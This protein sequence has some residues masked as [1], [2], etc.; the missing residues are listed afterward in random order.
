VNLQDKGKEAV[1]AGDD[2][3]DVI[4]GK[5]VHLNG[6]ATKSPIASSP[7]SRAEMPSP[8]GGAALPISFHPRG[9][10]VLVVGSNRLASS[11]AAAF[12]EA[13]GEVTIVSGSSLSATHGDIQERVRQSQIVYQQVSM[14]SLEEWAMY[15]SENDVALVCVT[16]T[17]IGSSQRS[18]ES[19]RIIS[20]ACSSLHI[21]VSVS[22]HPSLSTYTFPSVHRFAGIAGPSNLQIAVSTNGQ[23]CRLSSRIKREIISRLPHN[24]G[25][26]V[27]NVGRLREKA[28]SRAKHQSR[29][30]SEDDI[31]TPL[32][33]PVPQ[34]DTPSLLHRANSELFKVKLSRDEE[35]LRRM[36]WVHQMS[37]YYS[38]DHLANM[39][40][41]EM[42]EALETWSEELKVNEG[43][44]NVVLRQHHSS[45]KGRI[46]LVGSGPG[47]PGLLTV[48]ALKALQNATLI[49]SDKLVPSEIIALIPSTTKLHIAKKFPGNNEGAQNE[50]MELALAGAEAGE[51]VVRLKQGDP[52]I[53]GRGGEE[54]LY[55]RENGFEVTLIPGISSALAGPLMMGIP[56]TQRGVAE[57]FTLCTGVGRMG[58]K[59]TLPGYIKSRSLVVLMGVARIDQVISVL[60]TPEEEGR[61]GNPYP[62]YLP[63]GIIERASSP[64]QRIILSTIGG[65]EKALSGVEQRP[66]GMM[67][68]GWSA[69]CLEGK[70]RVDILD[71]EGEKEERKIVKEWLGG[72][73]WKIREGLGSDWTDLAGI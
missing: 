52:F 62:D 19:A 25:A 30:I 56:I 54:V 66:P 1:V 29:M 4:Q 20:Q 21:P 44:S 40:E 64:D 14:E 51:N 45:G 26:S 13:D 60:T 2:D 61:D 46:S 50:M 70:G 24:I 48:A 34:L 32:N 41:E 16:D 49:L 3:V 72:D 68:I 71:I 38:F 43:G 67:I 9:L 12:L 59:V 73:G 53:Y 65:I 35:Q 55:F 28:K 42:A 7:T 69:L 39:K 58:K 27:D 5:M 31:D 23:G 57:S 36:R 17:L 33:T 63:I 47:H 22:D 8:I 37:E 10:S 6:L 15:L 11:R 18:F